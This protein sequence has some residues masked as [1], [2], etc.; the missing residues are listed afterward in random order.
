[1]QDTDGEG[2]GRDKKQG[3]IWSAHWN[4]KIFLPIFSKKLI[5]SFYLAKKK[6]HKQT[7]S[8]KKKTGESSTIVE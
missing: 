7:R 8:T 4:V 1:M 2:E 5:W 6:N 3:T